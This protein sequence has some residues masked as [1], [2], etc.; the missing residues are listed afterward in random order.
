MRE[1]KG[2]I[3]AV[4][5]FLVFAFSFNVYRVEGDGQVYY[6]F[7][8]QTLDYFR[9]GD[10]R[11]MPRPAFCQ[12]GCAF[13]NMPFY[14][15]A[16]ALEKILP[17]QINI[18]NITLKT[19]SINLASNFY[20]V[21][22][23]L[24]MFRVLKQFNFKY[25]TIS[26]LSILFSTSAFSVAVVMPAYN[27]AVD[28]FINTLF[29][30]LAL[31]YIGKDRDKLY[32]LGAVYTLALTVRYFNIVLMIP[33]MVLLLMQRDYRKIR[34]VLY[35]L[36]ATIWI[37]PLLFYFF[38]GSVFSPAFSWSTTVAT[39]RHMSFFPRHLFKLLVHP[40]HGIFVWSPVTILSAVGLI[41]MTYAKGANKHIG[42]MLL[43][44]WI[45]FL[46]MYGGFNHWEAGW[47]FSSRYL[48]CLFPVYVIGLS[49]FLNKY[50]R[51]AVFLT[52]IGTLYSVF[53]F[54]NWHFSITHGAHGTPMDVVTAWM[55]GRTFAGSEIDLKIFLKRIWSYSR[56][57]Y[58]LRALV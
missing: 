8:E 5:A 42:Y 45:L 44:I 17:W 48:S 10:F 58:I 26:V 41:K 13:L 47:S 23:M 38:N 6:G 49:Y 9:N 39:M 35:G 43:G 24:M 56:Y 16:C 55:Q 36:L 22:S 7:L 54:F 46:V 32:W 19:A 11:V 21:L 40:V 52:V 3:I 15:S 25:K 53:L 57:K 28:I 20:M 18:P 1:Y 34:N 33:F 31:K 30:Y 51:K 14:L 37:L 29:V 4:F 27:H 2:E 50:G 12:V